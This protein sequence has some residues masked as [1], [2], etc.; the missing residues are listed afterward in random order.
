[1]KIIRPDDLWFIEYQRFMR[2]EIEEL[3]CLDC[4]EALVSCICN[5]NNIAG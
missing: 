3:I 4:G 1:M 2:E 5:D